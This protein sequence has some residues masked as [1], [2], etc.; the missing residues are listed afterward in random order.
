MIVCI[1]IITRLLAQLHQLYGFNTANV[2]ERQRKNSL[3]VKK[4]IY[5]Q[6][7]YYL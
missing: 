3:K 2:T 4:K 5:F 7:K 6:M 1:S